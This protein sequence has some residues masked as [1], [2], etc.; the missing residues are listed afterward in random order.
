MDDALMKELTVQATRENIAVV[1]GFVNA[2]LDRMNC[3]E[4]SRAQ[5]DIA[6]DEIFGNIANY[7][8][9]PEEGPA[10]VRIETEDVPLRV[11]ITFIDH[12]MQYDPL[13]AGD[14]DITLAA[15]ERRIGGLGVFMV[16]KTMDDVTYEYKD[17]K[18]ILTIRKVL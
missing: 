2:E 4:R 18:N 9:T 5:I 12:G 8:Y 13:S 17:G 1:T 6:I 10:T 11:S 15:R 16:K 7:A 3:P 14:P